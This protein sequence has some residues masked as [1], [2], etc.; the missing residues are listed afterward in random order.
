MYIFALTLWLVPFIFNT[1]IYTIMYKTRFI[2]T[3]TFTIGVIYSMVP[4]LGAVEMIRVLFAKRS[5]EPT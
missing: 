3:L 2:N 1:G 5:P 4:G